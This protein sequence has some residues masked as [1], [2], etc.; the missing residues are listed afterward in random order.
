MRKC[1]GVSSSPQV[2]LI[3]YY[4]HIGP[5]CIC[6]LLVSNILSVFVGLSNSFSCWG[7]PE[8]S[9]SPLFETRF[10]KF[11]FSS[12]FSFLGEENFG[13]RTPFL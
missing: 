11:G 3:D 12:R 6:S 13:V 9:W 5:V 1:L 2:H 4:C 8:T 10:G 7:Y